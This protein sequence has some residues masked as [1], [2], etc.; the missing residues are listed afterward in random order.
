MDSPSATAK[1]SAHQVLL[2]CSQP[3]QLLPWE[4]WLGKGACAFHT[5][6]P[7]RMGYSDPPSSANVPR[8][9]ALAAWSD[10][11]KPKAWERVQEQRRERLALAA[12]SALAQPSLA[13]CHPHMPWGIQR[14]GLLQVYNI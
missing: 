8:V 11:Q 12:W 10:S 14:P 13:G 6:S 5:S 2:A 7:N 4:F 9:F 3:L 1:L